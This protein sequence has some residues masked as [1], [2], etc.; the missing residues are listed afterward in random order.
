MSKL[1]IITGIV[2]VVLG[3][4]WNVLAKLPFVG[5]LPGDILIQKK[6]FT[7][8]F[9]ITTAILVSAILSLIFW[10]LSKR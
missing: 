1:L 5:R 6:N 10:L 8:Y 9:P 7:L 4:A 3:L 2:L